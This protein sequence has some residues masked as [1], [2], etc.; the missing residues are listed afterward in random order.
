MSMLQALFF[1]YHFELKL[2][3]CGTQKD[4]W[5]A[6]ISQEKTGNQNLINRIGVFLLSCLY[7]SADKCSFTHDSLN[8]PQPGLF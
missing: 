6:G 5:R 2:S 7:G 8:F 3:N 4:H 1:F